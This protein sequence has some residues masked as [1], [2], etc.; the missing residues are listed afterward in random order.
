[1]CIV[2]FNSIKC[3]LCKPKWHFYPQMRSSLAPMSLI[4]SNMF[5]L[6]SK[7]PNK[8]IFD[9][10]IFNTL[11]CASFAVE[12]IPFQLKWPSIHSKIH[13]CIQKFKSL[14]KYIKYAFKKKKH[15]DQYVQPPMVQF[16]TLWAF[17]HQCMPNHAP[18]HLQHEA[19][20]RLLQ[21]L[22]PLKIH[23]LTNKQSNI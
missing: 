4:L 22:K 10:N 8:V 3:D 1:M 16:P 21:T 9:S 23:S 19:P 6:N 14:F 7:P 11:K 18:M 20:Q 5:N 2:A 13:I 15:L 17:K 12:S